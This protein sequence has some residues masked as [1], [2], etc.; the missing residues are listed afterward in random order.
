MMLIDEQTRQVRELAAPAGYFFSSGS[1]LAVDGDG[2]IVT[3]AYTKGTWRLVRVNTQGVLV[4]SYALQ[5]SGSVFSLAV[6]G[7]NV[8][9]V[10][11]L[12]SQVQIVNFATGLSTVTTLARSRAREGVVFSDGSWL[13]AHDTNPD[14]GVTLARNGVTE[15]FATPSGVRYFSDVVQLDANRV[16]LADFGG[17]LVVFN[18]T[19]KS[20]GSLI[21]LPF[22]GVMNVY[23][24]GNT[25]YAISPGSGK[26]VLVDATTFAV[27]DVWSVADVMGLTPAPGGVWI[28]TN[29]SV[30]WRPTT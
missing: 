5:V 13:V 16:V 28:M 22:D 10:D 30:I 11:R 25:I 26:V 8:Q 2:N 21:Q 24:Q 23:F 19:T 18:A 20:Y 3:I 12:N 29:T 6:N 27:R 9:L 4:G 15:F 17:K 14:I 7:Q 1:P